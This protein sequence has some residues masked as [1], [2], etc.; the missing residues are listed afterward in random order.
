MAHLVY[1]IE[2]DNVKDLYCERVFLNLLLFRK[3]WQTDIAIWAGKK[4]LACVL[5]HDKHYKYF[6]EKYFKSSP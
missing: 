5:F 1:L 6:I 3:K 2:T 4:N